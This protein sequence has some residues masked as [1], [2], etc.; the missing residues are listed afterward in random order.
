MATDLRLDPGVC[1]K[2]GGRVF[3]IIQVLDFEKL[4]ARD[5]ATGKPEQLAI[6][7]VQPAEMDELA[8]ELELS[9]VLGDE[10]DEANRRYALIRPLLESARPGRKEVERVASGSGKHPTTIYRWIRLFR[11]TGKVSALLPTGSDGGRGKGRL[12][13]DVD[14]IIEATIGDYYLT[15]NQRSVQDACDEVARRCRAVGLKPPHPNTVRNRISAIGDKK[16]LELRGHAKQAHDRF[17]ARPGRYEDAAWPLSV[18]QID[19]TRLDIVAVDSIDRQPIGRPWITL[20]FDVFSRMVVGFYVSFDPP[21]ALATGL[22][23]AHA[24]LPKEQW[25]A[26]RGVDQQWPCWGVP[27]M[28]HMD[29]AREFRG[30]M[31]RRAC[32]EYGIEINFRPVKTPHFGAHIERMLGTLLSAIH[33]LA[34]STFS[35]P[36]KRGEQ[37]PD[38]TADKTIEEIEV[39][40]AEYICGIYHQRVHSGIG[41]TPLRRYDEGIFGTKD[42]P[43]TG[44]PARKSDEDRVRL[45]FMPFVERTIQTSGIVI[46]GIHYYSDVLRP[47]VGARNPDDRHSKRVFIFKRDPRD[48]SRVYFYDPDLRQY[49]E[50][51]YRNTSYPAISIW[52]LRKAQKKAEEDGAGAVDEAKIFE[53]H[54][55]IRELDEQAA[56]ETKRVRLARE[57]RSREV[58]PLRLVAASQSAPVEVEYQPV[59]P[60]E[61]IEEL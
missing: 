8:P 26:K 44:A 24:I 19:H 47:Y 4:L 32:E 52:E 34:G 20:A 53:T 2:S 40:I 61:G 41:T 9:T 60:Y 56:R 48:I 31:V 21:G 39:L 27:R 30:E 12:D 58:P 51:P 37:N 38:H 28:I 54:K 5:E 18:V 6:S 13:K 45:D 25:L 59:A 7:E 14:S 15:R 3:K 55:R 29:N 50:I 10:W 57:R 33:G 23:I 49:S 1:I 46:D 16:R 36:A 11:T 42:R 43:G 22:C 17:T 35:S